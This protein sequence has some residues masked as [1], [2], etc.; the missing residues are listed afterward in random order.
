M[1]KELWIAEHEKLIEEYL[2]S[3]PEAV[4]SEAYERTAELVDN[5]LRDRIADMIDEARD[6][7]K[8]EGV[9]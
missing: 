2:D 7:A 8:Y 9:K 5:R 1:S 3:H 6:R 4:W